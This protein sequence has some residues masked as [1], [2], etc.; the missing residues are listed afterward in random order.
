MWEFP[1]LL[2]AWELEEQGKT[3]WG[4]NRK[5]GVIEERMPRMLERICASTYGYDGSSGAGSVL[6]K[7]QQWSG[8]FP[9]YMK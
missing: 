3:V 4:F 6:K 9:H 7:S 5:H 2:S 1:S 8:G